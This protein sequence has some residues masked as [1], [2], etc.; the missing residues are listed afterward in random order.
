MEAEPER[1]RCRD[2]T[3]HSGK[4]T[5]KGKRKVGGTRKTKDSREERGGVG[6][7]MEPLATVPKTQSYY[8][9]RH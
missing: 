5:P 2:R 4:G 9:P 6:R 8:L 7:S 1:T 3:R